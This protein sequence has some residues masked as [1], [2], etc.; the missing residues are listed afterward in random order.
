MSARNKLRTL[1]ATDKARLEKVAPLFDIQFEA[2]PEVSRLVLDSEEV[3]EVPSEFGHFRLLAELCSRTV[4]WIYFN[5]SQSCID[6]FLGH[7]DERL[8]RFSVLYQRKKAS[9]DAGEEDDFSMAA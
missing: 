9:A 1:S 5:A 7:T 8:R 4:R 6:S 2:G 3:I